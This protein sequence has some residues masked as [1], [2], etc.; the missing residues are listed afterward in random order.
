MPP[1]PYAA[2]E[3]RELSLAAAEHAVVDVLVA[4]EDHTAA[5]LVDDAAEG[6][7]RMQG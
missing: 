3:L 1:Y 5:G 7:Q 2:E 4:G 6:L